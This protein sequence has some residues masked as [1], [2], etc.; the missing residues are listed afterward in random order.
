MKDK[1]ILLL[2]P[3]ILLTIILMGIIL[4]DNYNTRSIN[5]KLKTDLYNARKEIKKLKEEKLELVLKIPEN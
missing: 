1:K 5:N 4:Y 3:L 2:I